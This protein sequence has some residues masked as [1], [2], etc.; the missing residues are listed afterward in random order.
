[1]EFFF[2]L[3]YCAI[4]NL[5]KKHVLKMADNILHSK[6]ITLQSRISHGVV[7]AGSKLSV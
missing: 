3:N 7:E 2:L 1:M 4:R 6:R 5:H